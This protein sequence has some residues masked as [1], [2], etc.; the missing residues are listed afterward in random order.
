M[1]SRSCT[2]GASLL[3]L[4]A[5]R[6]LVKIPGSSSLALQ[7]PRVSGLELVLR[8]TPQ[9]KTCRNQPEKPSVD[10]KPHP[11]S[12]ALRIEGLS[13]STSGVHR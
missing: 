5:L 8:A 1:E 4:G 12:V 13:L 9:P 2:V 11:I 3:A 7:H 10:P 6:F